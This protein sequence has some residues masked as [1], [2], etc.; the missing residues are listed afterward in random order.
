ME[1]SFALINSNNIRAM[2]KELITFL[3]RAEPEFKA[4]CSSNIVLSAERF[5]PDKRWHL[6]TL[7]KVLV[8]VSFIF[9]IILKKIYIYLKLTYLFEKN[10]CQAGNYVRDDVVSCTIQLISESTAHQTY[11]VGQLWQA[12]ERDT[13]DRQPLTQIATWCIGEYGDLLLYSQPGGDEEKSINVRNKKKNRRFDYF[14]S[15]ATILKT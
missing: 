4:Q 9:D 8:A 2:V 10:K 1:L 6:D 14:K 5:A 3:E 12:L 7:L 15:N 11:M 13:A